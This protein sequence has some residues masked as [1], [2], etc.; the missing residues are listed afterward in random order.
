MCS[1]LEG[2]EPY[3]LITVINRSRCSAVSRV[4]EFSV[5]LFRFCSMKI[6]SL[7]ALR[8]YRPPSSAL[9]FLE[10]RVFKIV[11]IENAFQTAIVVIEILITQALIIRV[12]IQ[13]GF[14]FRQPPC[15]R[16][17]RTMLSSAVFSCST[18]TRPMRFGCIRFASV[19][20]TTACF[21]CA[22]NEPRRISADLIVKEL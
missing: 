21:C 20:V 13:I 15:G 10:V 11:L 9:R 1:G 17:W 19:R 6:R 14:C 12:L 18:P 3:H 2:Q 7:V 16:S 22:A 4:I 5:T 8:S